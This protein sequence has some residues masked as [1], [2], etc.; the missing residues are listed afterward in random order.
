M[1]ESRYDSFLLQQAVD[2]FSR[3]PGI[4]PKSALRM[5]LYLLRQPA[6]ES[7]H[8]AE[9]IRNLRDK[10]VYCSE[11]R[12]ISDAPVCPVCSDPNRDR[13]VNLRGGEC[14][15]VMS[16]EHTGRYRGLYMCWEAL[17]LP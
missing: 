17:F 2:A 9:S 7:E 13:R 12:M 4:G 15:G 11:C 14:A 10:V 5:A 16:I 6:P 1:F 3:L 8:L